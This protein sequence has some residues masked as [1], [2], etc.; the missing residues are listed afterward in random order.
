[1]GKPVVA[2]DVPGCRQV[3]RHGSTGL[4]CESRSS[5]SLARAMLAIVDMPPQER[6]AMGLRGRDLVAREY[7]ED[8][9]VSQYIQILREI[10]VLGAEVSNNRRR[11]KGRT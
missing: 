3:V 9:V 7:S 1:M 5:F 6:V 8:R 11:A 10:G 2:T 4:L